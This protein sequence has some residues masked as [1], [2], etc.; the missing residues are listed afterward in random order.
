M[1]RAPERAAVYFMTVADFCLCS[2]SARIITLKQRGLQPQTHEAEKTNQPTNPIYGLVCARARRALCYSNLIFILTFVLIQFLSTTR[3][4]LG[5]L[6]LHVFI[7][8]A[9]CASRGLTLLVHN[10]FMMWSNRKNLN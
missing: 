6:R 4:L 5:R 8:S 2:S 3:S 7:H 9:A 1:V 10:V